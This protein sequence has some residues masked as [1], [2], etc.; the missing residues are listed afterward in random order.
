[1]DLWRQL[2]MTAALLAVAGAGYYGW[3]TYAPQSTGAERRGGDAPGVVRAV[4]AREARLQH[5]VEAVGSTRARRAIELV[6]LASGRVVEV[7]FAAG[8]TVAAGAPLVRLD[9]DIERADLAEAEAL[10]REAELA[11][12]RARTLRSTAAVSEA[13]IDQ[14]V[15]QRATAQARVDRAARRLADRLV[16]APFAGTVGLARVDVGARVDDDTVLTTLDDLEAI[17]VAFDLP[18]RLFGQIVAGQSVRGRSAAFAGRVFE[19]AVEKVDSRIDAVTRSFAVRAVL[20]N[21]DRALPAGMFMHLELVVASRVALVVPEEAILVTG[22]RAFVFAVHDGR[23][24][25]SE[26]VLG[27]REV[28]R[29]EIVEGLETGTL[30]VVEGVQRVRDGMPVEVDGEPPGASRA[31]V[32]A[33][34]AAGASG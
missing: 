21:P 33:T 28:G 24:R 34:S 17:E 12:D 27:Q 30:V 29:V 16:E 1:M 15:A 2:L 22:D 5:R 11:L 18:E 3:S 32:A 4:E 26:V 7:L 14:L 20:P 25:R 19:G 31:P 10:L 6:P 13:A 9:D 23:A 8:D